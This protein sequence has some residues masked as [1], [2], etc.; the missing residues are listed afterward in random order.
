MGGRVNGFVPGAMAL[1]TYVQIPPQCYV[2]TPTLN[3]NHPSHTYGANATQPTQPYGAN[4]A[5]PT[6]TYGANT[7][8]LATFPTQIYGATVAPFTNH[9]MQNYDPNTVNFTPR[10]TQLCDASTVTTS[11]PSNSYYHGS[12]YQNITKMPN[13]P[14]GP[15]NDP[16][17]N[18]L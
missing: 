11:L 9:P 5:H 18:T 15:P 7:T 16:Q 4:A 6:Q 13:P 10:P 17:K 2:Q 1:A 3:T 8:T 14:N 12:H